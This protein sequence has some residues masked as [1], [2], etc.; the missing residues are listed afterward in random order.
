MAILDAL[1]LGPQ[2]LSDLV[3]ATQIARPTA[4]RLALALESHGMVGRDALGRFVLGGRIT[5][6]ATAANAEQ[7]AV[8]ARPLLIDLRD[9]TG[10]ST[11]LYR[12][13]GDSRVCIAGADLSAGLRDTVPVGAVLT[14]AAGSAAQVLLAWEEAASARSLAKSATFSGATLATVRRRGWAQSVAEREAGVASVSAPV[15]AGTDRVVAAVSLSGPIDRLGRSPGKRHASA[16]V[17]TARA[18]SRLIEAA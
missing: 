1:E 13:E 4:H 10:E 5:E 11:Q 16:V 3:S 17:A 7:L 12:R 2:S 8:V 18:L 9:A 14:M 15:R 6:L